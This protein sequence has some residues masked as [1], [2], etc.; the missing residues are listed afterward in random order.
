MSCSV[1]SIS[2]SAWLAS[3]AAH[4]FIPFC[5]DQ[6]ISLPQGLDV[7]R[8]GAAAAIL[9]TAVGAAA[10]MLVAGNE[11]EGTSLVD[12]VS[13]GVGPFPPFFEHPMTASIARRIRHAGVGME[14]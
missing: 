12:A 13:L 14:Q 8:P 7:A 1:V 9:V 2:F 4:S 3:R 10:L 6:Y 5:E 11:L